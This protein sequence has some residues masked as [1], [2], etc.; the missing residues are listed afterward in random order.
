MFQSAQSLLSMDHWELRA[1]EKAAIPGK[2]RNTFQSL[3]SETVAEKTTLLK[4]LFTGL[5]QE[6]LPEKKIKLVHTKRE[7]EMKNS[8][9]RKYE[10]AHGKEGMGTS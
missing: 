3:T 5:P 4:A 9:H 10:W 8:H 2:I 7:K 6:A 1:F